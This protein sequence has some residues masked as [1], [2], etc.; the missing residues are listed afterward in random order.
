MSHDAR[1]PFALG[2]L[3]FAVLLAACSKQESSPPQASAEAMVSHDSAPAP[4]AAPGSAAAPV[5]LSTPVAERRVIRRAELTLASQSVAETANEAA[6]VVQ[7]AG[8]YVENRD[9]QHAGE[10]VTES[11]LSLRVPA[12][13]FA[14]VLDDLKRG[15]RVVREQVSGQDV[16]AEFVDVGARLKTQRVLEER[17]LGLSTAQQGVEDLLEVERE[18]A[19]VRSQIEQLEGRQRVLET[20]TSYGTLH[21][22]IRSPE[23]PRVA[24][25]VGIGSRLCNAASEGL[26]LSVAVTVGLI[27]VGFAFLPFLPLPICGYL[28]LRMRRRRQALGR[29]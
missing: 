5:D 13:A 3:I 25:I 12:D 26:E 16:T 9:D 23:Q 6:G 17:L 10:Q 11:T 24:S 8:G 19:R 2:L 7:R 14:T 1:P 28:L 21:V 22:V 4:A 27:Q 15:A 20:Q 18:L 29:A